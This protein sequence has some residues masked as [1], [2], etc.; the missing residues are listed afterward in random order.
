[1]SEMKETTAICPVSFIDNKIV[2]DKDINGLFMNPYNYKIN[3]DQLHGTMINEIQRNY[4]DKDSRSFRDWRYDI[5]YTTER[6]NSLA[7]KTYMITNISDL[8]RNTL[9]KF[10]EEVFFDKETLKAAEAEG[11][12]APN[13]QAECIGSMFGGCFESK[14]N[15]EEEVRNALSCSNLS[16]MFNNDDR[17]T[18]QM[19]YVL[20]D[21]KMSALYSMLVSNVFD[22]FIVDHVN[23]ALTHQ[24]LDQLY[25]FLY[26]KCFNEDPKELPNAQLE[27]SFC[28]G[29][30][31]EIMDQ[32]LINFRAALVCVSKNISLMIDQL[33]KS[34]KESNLLVD[35]KHRYDEYDD[36]F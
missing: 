3:F 25:T 23:V 8:V 29:M 9:I 35:K 33:N 19:I 14:I 28:L 26:Y 17:L 24:S 15:I 31:R 18:V 34:A 12:K 36:D 1:M 10:M 4:K 32:C 5:Q 13:T 7:L 6:V 22:R 20:T 30:M 2:T 16:Q 27:Y 21:M 11:F